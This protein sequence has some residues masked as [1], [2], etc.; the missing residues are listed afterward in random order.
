[1][2]SPA[3]KTAIKRRARAFW[4]D[5]PAVTVDG[6]Q[7]EHVP[8]LARYLD[9]EYA[10]I[11]EKE[12]VGKGR[13]Y[14]GRTV[15]EG[16]FAGFLRAPL[17]VDSGRAERVQRVVAACVEIFETGQ[18]EGA[19]LLRVFAVYLLAGVAGGVPGGFHEV[20]PR[21]RSW[22]THADWEVRE[23]VGAILRATLKASPAA[24]IPVMETWIQADDEN[25]RRVVT[26]SLRPLADIKW[27]R[28]SARNDAV[29]GLLA[30]C[31][32]DPSTYV[33]KSVGNNLKDL[34][35]Y[36][37]EKILALAATWIQEAGIPVTPDLAA[38]SKRDLGARDFYLVW[39]LKQALRWLQARHPEYHAQLRAV[40]GD[41]YVRYFDEKRN[42]RCLPK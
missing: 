29:L 36:M 2:V 38:R 20:Q 4:S 11:P 37:P 24:V 10:D 3:S 30:Q 14:I 28:D 7:P 25:L 18:A 34:T 31:R 26:E 13:V 19:N 42:R 35:K 21:A 33:R 32:A 8:A 22:A 1:M 12:R 39:T 6:V 9:Q 15:A 41:Q 23:M 17:S 5:H 16:V 27:L 40:L